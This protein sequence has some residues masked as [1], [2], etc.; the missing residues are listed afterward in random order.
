MH[1][2]L[3]FV[4]QMRS[5]FPFEVGWYDALTA[6]VSEE[7]WRANQLPLALREVYGPEQVRTYQEYVDALTRIRPDRLM[8][9]L[10]YWPRSL[11]RDIGWV[12]SRRFGARVEGTG[13]PDINFLLRDLFAR[14]DKFH[15]C[16]PS[17]SPFRPQPSASKDTV[18]KGCLVHD[19][20]TQAVYSMDWYVGHRL[21]TTQ[22][23]G[24]IR[25]TLD[26]LNWKE[27]SEAA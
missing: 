19:L 10:L 21:V 13:F 5:D 16:E 11:P 3:K 24:G 27:D 15:Q 20:K 14:A 18:P 25:E 1:Y 7:R 23:G 22:I 17:D 2:T 8:V 6:P 26:L 4:T 9:Y 12:Q